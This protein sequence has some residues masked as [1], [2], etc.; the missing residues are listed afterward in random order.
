MTEEEYYSIELLRRHK[1]HRQIGALEKQFSRLP[2]AADPYS[3]AR[4][5]KLR[6]KIA[7]LKTRLNLPE[8]HFGA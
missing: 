4:R 2:P 1:L 8:L 5:E 3:V 6:N 7:N